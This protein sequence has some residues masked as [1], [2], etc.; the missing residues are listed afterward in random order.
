MKPT[1]GGDDE[2]GLSGLCGDGQLGQQ[3]TVETKDHQHEARF[4]RFIV[5]AT[6]RR[7]TEYVF[8]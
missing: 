5:L 4:G 2:L 6:A 7:T 8:H 3:G 1:L